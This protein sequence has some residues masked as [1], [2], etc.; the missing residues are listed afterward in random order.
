MGHPDKVCRPDVQYACMPCLAVT[1]DLAVMRTSCSLLVCWLGTVPAAERLISHVT[2]PLQEHLCTSPSDGQV[3][4][5]GCLV[6][7]FLSMQGCSA[8]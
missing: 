6:F 3:V 5:S 4:N 8:G 7:Y 2:Y 1:T